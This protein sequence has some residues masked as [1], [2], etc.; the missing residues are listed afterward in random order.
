[1]KHVYLSYYLQEESPVYV[2]LKKP[3]IQSE[4][5]IPRDGYNTSIISVENHSGTH[6]DAPAHFLEEGK[7]ISD[8][9]L[10][11][12]IFNRVMLWECEKNSHELVTVEDLL[13]SHLTESG[14]DNVD[15]L[16]IRTGFFKYRKNNVEKYLTHNP[17]ISEDLIHY[18]REKFPQIRALGIDCVSISPYTNP[19]SANK[20]HKTAFLGSEDFNGDTCSEPLLL[21]EDMKLQAVPKNAIIEKLFIVPWQLKGVD[22]APCSVIAQ[23]K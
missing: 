15:C 17:G 16:L 18:L 5:S 22:S 12:F 9:N 21:I 3:S 14:L 20:A 19:A 8:Y 10:S 23:L 1:M 11:E 7:T 4:C 2:G 13:E 6:V